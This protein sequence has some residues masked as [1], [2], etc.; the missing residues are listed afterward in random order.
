[1]MLAK[2]SASLTV[3]VIGFLAIEYFLGE[4]LVMYEMNTTG[5][6]SRSELA[7]DYGMGIIGVIFVP[8]VSAILSA[9]LGLGVW[10][11]FSK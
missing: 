11:V 6:K 9:L 1:M 4:A 3:V 10:K 5:A 8:P 7:E 2:L